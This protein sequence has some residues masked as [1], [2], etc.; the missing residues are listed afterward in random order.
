M[1]QTLVYAPAQGQDKPGPVLSPGDRLPLFSVTDADS[2][3]KLMFFINS[4][5]DFS[6]R[7]GERVSSPS[8]LLTLTFFSG[9]EEF[10]LCL[11]AS[12]QPLRV[13]CGQKPSTLRLRELRVESLLGTEVAEAFGWVAADGAGFPVVK[14]VYV[15]CLHRPACPRSGLLPATK[16]QSEISRGAGQHG[17]ARNDRRE[18]RNPTIMWNRFSPQTPAITSHSSRVVHSP[19][20]GQSGISRSGLLRIS[21]PSRAWGL[22]TRPGFGPLPLHACRTIPHSNLSNPDWRIR[23]T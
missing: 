10:V 11:N 18:G 6:L 8:V 12:S 14:A 4:I 23:S 2:R 5:S 7:S 9:C 16:G 1:P 20:K 17:G 15:F 3:M 19:R 13:L 22:I 21:K